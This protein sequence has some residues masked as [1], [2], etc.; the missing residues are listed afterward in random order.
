[1]V[2]LLIR[3]GHSDAVGRW[4][5]GRRDGVPL[6]AAGRRDAERLSNALRWLPI[7]AIYSSPLERAVDTAQPLARDHG[8]HVATRDALVDVDFGEWTGK[9]LDELAPLPEW[10]TFNRDRSRARAPAGESLKGVQR[11]MVEELT[12]LAR[13]HEGET[14]AIITHAEP[15]RC[16]IASFD[17]RTLNDVLAVEIS[18]AH[19]SSV[20]ISANLRRVLSINLRPE[21]AGV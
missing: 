1:M 7:A 6:N 9:T 13:R 8:L 21:L 5:A 3:H 14:V 2:G 12:T 17:G 16:A 20:G 19:V 10:Q 15:I 18:P 11:R 4:L